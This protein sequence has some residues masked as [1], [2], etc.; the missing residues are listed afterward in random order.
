MENQENYEG[1]EDYY[2]EEEETN[3]EKYVR[4][5]TFLKQKNIYTWWDH[6]YSR[7]INGPDALD[8]VLDFDRKITIA[9]KVHQ[10]KDPVAYFDSLIDK[11]EEQGRNMT[12]WLIQQETYEMCQPV[13][14]QTQKLLTELDLLKSKVKQLL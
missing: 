4:V 13:K 11:L 7:D 1:Y 10:E 6:H 5:D 14:D 8:F 2:Y 3:T 12:L 9:Q